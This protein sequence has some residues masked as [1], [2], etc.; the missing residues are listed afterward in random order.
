MRLLEQ[1]DFEPH[2][3]FYHLK[4]DNSI[5]EFL[6]GKITDL[7]AVAQLFYSD[8]FKK[9]GIK[10]GSSFKVGL[11]ISNDIDLL[12]MDLESEDIPKEELKALFRSFQLKKKYYRLKDGSFINLEDEHIAKMSNILEDLN[13]SAKSLTLDPIKLSKNKAFYLE[14]ALNGSNL[15]VEK[16]EDFTK[17]IDTILHPANREYVIP[18]KVDATLRPYQNVGYRWLRSLADN[19][20][21]G[22]LADDMGLGK[23]LQS[24]VYITS[25][26]E[27]D[28]KAN[29]KFL[30]VCPTSLVYNWLDEFESFAPHLRAGVVSGNPSERQE[31]IEQINEFDV[32]VTSYPLIRRDI[33]HYQA[34]T[35]HTVFIDEAQFIKNAASINAQSV[36]LLNSAHRF[37]L[38]GTP[39]ENSL[40]EL[41]SIFD[42]IMPGYLMTHSKF[43]NQYEKQILKEDTEALANLNRRIHPFILRRMKK[44]VLNDLPDKLEEKIVTEM[45]DEQKKVYVSYLAEIRNDI[46]SEIATKGIEKSQM[47]ILAALTRLRQICCHPST[48]LEHYDGGSGKLD[49]LLEVIEEALANDHRILVFSQ[50]TSMLKIMEGELKKLSVPYFY[51]E[52][53]TPISERNEYVKRFNGGEG[54]VFLIS[55]KAGGTG[56]NLVGADTVIHY[57]PWWNPAVEEQ[58]TDR[59][60]RIG[61]KNNVHVIKLLT[62]NTIEEKIF[63]LQKKKKEL[64]DSIIQSKEVFINTLS[65]EELEEIFS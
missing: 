14:D 31:R 33:K 42:F 6:T 18:T 1:L 27:E 64:S 26:L 15:Y 16:N 59:V 32:L 48:F 24:I 54:S 8:S 55:L 13:V 19:N 9:L 41:W 2:S 65:K 53:S 5:Y 40:S 37:A 63:K 25:I 22:I 23:T 43:V 29:E 58:A 12:E 62:K 21:G 34:I 35:F 60:Y 17:L 45:T 57:D 50:F 47:K 44:D 56:L 11:R 51:L 28:P 36:K 20:L 61:Q 39:I 3:T 10:N 4:N 30:I 46:Y 52:G 49:L 7:Q 38:T